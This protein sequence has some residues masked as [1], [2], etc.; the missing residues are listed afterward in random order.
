LSAHEYGPHDYRNDAQYPPEPV[1][2]ELS[3]IRN[4][5]RKSQRPEGKRKSRQTVKDL[6]QDEDDQAEIAAAQD[7]VSQHDGK[8]GPTCHV[9]QNG[10]CN[11]TSPH[12]HRVVKQRDQR[13]AVLLFRQTGDPAGAQQPN[14]QAK[15]SN[16]R[17]C[18]VSL[19]I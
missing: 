6:E 5:P 16:H 19:A 18:E 4:C 14:Q 17:C 13:I 10:Q 7:A 9:G 8:V 2:H 12:S 1:I 11:E 3:M 15:D